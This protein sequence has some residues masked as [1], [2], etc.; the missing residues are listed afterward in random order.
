MS[1]CGKIFN[2][3]VRTNNLF[4]V[5]NLDAD[6]T[7]HCDLKTHL[8]RCLDIALVNNPRRVMKFK[9]ASEPTDNIWENRHFVKSETRSREFI[10]FLI[11]GFLLFL[12]F[13]FI[14]KVSRLSSSIAKTFP[15][16]SC[17]AINNNYGTQ[18]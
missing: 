15:A 2:E 11:I 9:N 13:L 5:N 14:F 18:L 7:T 1:T 12:S 10:A 16:V 8:N 6:P 17:E 4:V 3:Q